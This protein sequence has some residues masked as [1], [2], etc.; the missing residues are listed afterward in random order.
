[1]GTVNPEGAQTTAYVKYG[2]DTTY[3]QQ[4]PSQDLGPALGGF[5]AQQVTA[6]FNGLSAGITYHYRLAATNSGG[7]AYGQD[8]VFTTGALTGGMP[9]VLNAPVSGVTCAGVTI[10]GIVNPNGSDT[11]ASVQ[12]GLSTA[13]GSVSTAQDLGSGGIDLPF[14]AILAGLQS[15]TTY[16]YRIVAT[17]G[18]G[19]TYGTDQTFNTGVVGIFSF[20]PAQA[21]AG[22]TLTLNGVGFTGASSVTF[23]QLGTSSTAG[24]VVLSG[25][26]MAVTVPACGI[27]GG[28]YYITLQTSAGLTVTLDPAASIVENGQYVGSGGGA[29]IYVEGG[30]A[31]YNNGSG[32]DTY[33]IENGGVLNGSGGGGGNIAY[34]APGATVTLSGVSVIQVPGVDQSPVSSLFQ[35]LAPGLAFTGVPVSINDTTATVSGTVN[36]E[37]TTTTAC[38]Q[39]G[40]VSGSASS[41]VAVANVGLPLTSSSYQDQTPSVTVGS[42][43]SNVPLSVNLSTLT[44]DTAYHYRV[45][46]VNGGGATYGADQQFTTAPGPID[47]WKEGYFNSQQLSNSSVSGDTANPAGDGVPNLLKYALGMNP[48]VNSVAGLPVCGMATAS[49]TAYYTF[50]FA[51]MDSATDISYNP[52]WCGD[53]SSWSGAGLIQQVLSDNGTTQQVRASLPASTVGNVFFRLNVTWQ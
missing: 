2:T 15:G 51:K 37:G 5:S 53:L 25:S 35:F 45:V 50:T 22:T 7:T 18:A 14:Q 42:G 23:S 9:G 3:G 33:F 11:M 52:Q 31:A 16:H 30:G 26:Q 12:Y 29:M 28:G 21:A 17:N 38:I 4:T 1:N 43:T 10:N 32:S 27:R 41:S 34:A 47:Y 13:Y 36:A 19:A 24:F 20:S 46:V 39:Y 8:Q 48:N 40:V 49:G 44:S 6:S